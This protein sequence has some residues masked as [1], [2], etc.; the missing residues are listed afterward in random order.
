MGGRAVTALWPGYEQPTLASA[1]VPEDSWEAGRLPAA[2]MPLTPD[3]AA[4]AALVAAGGC[5]P[6]C[7]IPVAAAADCKC[8]CRGAYHGALADTDVALALKHRKATAR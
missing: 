5:S 4:A 1:D 6:Q 8:A 2:P 7:L 3:V